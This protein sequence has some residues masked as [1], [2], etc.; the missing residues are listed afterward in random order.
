M[1][2]CSARSSPWLVL[3]PSL[4]PWLLS[5][6]AMGHGTSDVPV[7]MSLSHDRKASVW[8][9]LAGHASPPDPPV[10]CVFSLPA[11]VEASFPALDAGRV[12]GSMSCPMSA[13]QILAHGQCEAVQH[14]HLLLR[15][16]VAVR[17][18]LP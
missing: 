12:M 5:Y 17:S 15:A 8:P 18:V 7:P 4:A 6:R 2:F 16:P 14:R 3:L 10:F 13:L 9:W 11:A 1:S